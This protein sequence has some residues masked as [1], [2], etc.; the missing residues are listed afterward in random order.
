MLT[1]LILSAF[2]ALILYAG[3]DL[4]LT[5]TQVL[6]STGAKFLHGLSGEALTHGQV[7]YKKAA[8][9]LYWLA[10]A[11]A[12]ASAAAVGVVMCEAVAAGQEIVVQ[13]EGDITL[14]AGAAPARG[15]LYLVSPTAGGYAPAPA[16]SGDYLTVI[17]YGIGSNKIR[18]DINVTGI[19]AA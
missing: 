6:P 7:V 9:G 15:V 12:E 3:V 5:A 17:G 13:V 8:D 18:L 16:A 11:D 19:A 4:T 1:L 14:G 10:D 2:V